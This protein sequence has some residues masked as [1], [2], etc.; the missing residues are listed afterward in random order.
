MGA[1]VSSQYSNKLQAKSAKLLAGICC[2]KAVKSI[3]A[4]E[5]SDESRLESFESWAQA[6][7]TTSICCRLNDRLCPA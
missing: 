7:K 4:G 2:F 5:S 3:R 1:P 6:R